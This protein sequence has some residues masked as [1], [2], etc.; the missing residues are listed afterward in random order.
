MILLRRKTNA[1][2]AINQTHPVIWNSAEWRRAVAERTACLCW[3]PSFKNEPEYYETSE[4]IQRGDVY[5]PRPPQHWLPVGSSASLRASCKVRRHRPKTT[6]TVGRE[7]GSDLKATSRLSLGT[8]KQISLKDVSYWR[9][10]IWVLTAMVFFPH[11]FTPT[12]LG[13]ARRSTPSTRC[14][15]SI[16]LNT[17]LFFCTGGWVLLSLREALLT[18]PSSCNNLSAPSR[19]WWPY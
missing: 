2:E 12:F 14:R 7:F 19:G 5:L 10:L 17:Q 13:R 6:L 15:T 4:L 8:K 9:L 18:C 1:P 16:W 11:L 3:C